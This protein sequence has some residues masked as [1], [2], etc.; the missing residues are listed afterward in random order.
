MLCVCPGQRKNDASEMATI[1]QPRGANG[2][3]PPKL[4]GLYAA[5]MLAEGVSDV[6]A[7]RSWDPGTP[8]RIVTCP[9]PDGPTST[10]RARADGHPRGGARALFGCGARPRDAPVP[11]AQ[12]R[13]PDS[14]ERE[15][16]LLFIVAIIIAICYNHSYY[17]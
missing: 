11:L 14:A 3:L 9:W 10:P 7:Y 16:L 8:A 17:S 13:P 5:P 6:P 12:G 4:I 1:W 15:Q 2:S